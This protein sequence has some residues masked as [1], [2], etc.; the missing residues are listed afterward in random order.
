M[1][2]VAACALG[3]LIGLALTPGALVAVTAPFGDASTR[4]RVKTRV[5]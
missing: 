2:I 4:P 3:A 5:L 1:V